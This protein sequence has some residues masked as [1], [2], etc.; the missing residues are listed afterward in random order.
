VTTPFHL[1][2]NAVG[3]TLMEALGR[4]FTGAVG[5]CGS[6]G[7]I[8]VLATLRVHRAGPGDVLRCPACDAILLVLVRHPT[9]LRLHFAALAWLQGG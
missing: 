5:C 1:D 6:C 4:D 3:G 7:A 9:G 8:R 2:G